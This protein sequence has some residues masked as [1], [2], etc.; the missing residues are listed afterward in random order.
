MREEDKLFRLA[1]LRIRK[2]YTIEQMA[3]NIGVTAEEYAAYEEE[4]RRPSLE[5]LSRI[6][7][8]LTPV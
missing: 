8:F 1:E 4:T 3:E 6:C 7:D 5:S 2:N